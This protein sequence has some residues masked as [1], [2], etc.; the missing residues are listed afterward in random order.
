MDEEALTF[1]ERQSLRGIVDGQ[2]DVLRAKIVAALRQS[3]RP[4]VNG[5][6]NPIHDAESDGRGTAKLA[7]ELAPAGRHVS[8]LRA[9]LNARTRLDVGGE[10]RRDSS[11]KVLHL[12]AGPQTGS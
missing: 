2:I 6:V 5:L 10:E 11:L 9:L 4:G 1:A 8:E 12:A 3:E 7:A